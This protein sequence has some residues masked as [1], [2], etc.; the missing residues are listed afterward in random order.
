MNSNRELSDTI[1]DFGCIE[2]Y[3]KTGKLDA[4][5]LAHLRAHGDF[6]LLLEETRF[7]KK[8]ALERL[9]SLSNPE[10]AIIGENEIGKSI[11]N[12]MNRIDAKMAI[13]NATATPDT[14]YILPRYFK[15]EV[16][17]YAFRGVHTELPA[18]LIPKIVASDLEI[19]YSEAYKKY[20]NIEIIREDLID[21]VGETSFF[22]SFRKYYRYGQTHKLLK[23]TAYRNFY[24]FR[25]RK[26]VIPDIK[27]L[28]VVFGVYAVRGI[29][30]FLGYYFG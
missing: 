2:I 18:D 21:K 6:E 16:M 17:D 20:T 4:R 5:E 15:R 30:F 14:L 26:R 23:G 9:T 7:L 19:I 8:N 3:K 25:S 22:E 28:P 13:L 27:Y 29:G 11:V 24:S 10:M 12:K 1:K